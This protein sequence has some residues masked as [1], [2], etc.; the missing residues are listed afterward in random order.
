MTCYRLKY[1][2]NKKKQYKKYQL[3]VFYKNRK[4]FKWNFTKD[5]TSY[6]YKLGPIQTKIL[7]YYLC[8]YRLTMNAFKTTDIIIIYFILEQGYEFQWS[9]LLGTPFKKVRKI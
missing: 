8:R 2:P 6:E 7:K 9:I 5:N 4:T 3:I 1:K